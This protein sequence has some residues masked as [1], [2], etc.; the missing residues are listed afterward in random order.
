M[1]K[2]TPPEPLLEVLWRDAAIDGVKYGVPISSPTFLWALV[3]VQPIDDCLKDTLMDTLLPL[4]KKDPYQRL[5]RRHLERWAFM[6]HALDRLEKSWDAA[7]SWCADQLTKKGKSVSPATV[8]RSYNKV[9]AW[10][11]RLGC[12]RPRTYRRLR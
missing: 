10:Q 7:P 9:E 12:G 3:M 1:T 11:R 4:I 8:L 6:R 2:K 5:S